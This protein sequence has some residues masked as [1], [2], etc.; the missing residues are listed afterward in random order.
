MVLRLTL[1]WFRQQRYA[2]LMFGGIV[3]ALTMQSAFAANVAFR[4]VAVTEVVGGILGYAR[5]PADTTTAPPGKLQLCV[6]GPTEYADIL[7]QHGNPA[8]GSIRLFVG[9]AV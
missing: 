6:V 8:S 5:W 3:V 2:I 7:R 1:L 9:E 4:M